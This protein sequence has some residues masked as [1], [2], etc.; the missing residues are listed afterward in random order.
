MNN[1]KTL[2]YDRIDAFGRIDINN[3]SKSKRVR[4]FSR[5]VLFR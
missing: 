3:I 4:Y 1:V 2:Y 5:L